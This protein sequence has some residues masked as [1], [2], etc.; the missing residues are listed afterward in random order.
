MEGVAAASD[1]AGTG[2]KR[3]AAVGRSRPCCEG[4]TTSKA[5]NAAASDE[6]GS[7]TTHQAAVGLSIFQQKSSTSAEVRDAEALYEAGTATKRKAD[8]SG[9]CHDDELQ[10]KKVKLEREAASD[11]AGGASTTDQDDDVRAL[12]AKQLEA[13][14]N[15]LANGHTAAQFEAAMKAVNEIGTIAAPLDVQLAHLQAV[16]IDH[17]TRAIL[18]ASK[19]HYVHKHLFNAAK[20]YRGALR[21]AAACDVALDSI[22]GQD[23]YVLSSTAV[24]STRAATPSLC[25]LCSTSLSKNWQA[26]PSSTGHAPQAG[27]ASSAQPADGEGDD[28][29]V[30]VGVTLAGERLKLKTAHNEADSAGKQSE[31][32][33]DDAGVRDAGEGA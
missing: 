16:T 31:D 2:T 29:V 4:G 32:K 28:E 30:V 27:A 23:E 14:E 26:C 7:G 20:K 15:A 1:E 12:A 22:N 8:S 10:G 25:K 13:A 6:A 33:V 18:M 17:R 19:L 24:A 21:W 9:L 3:Q 5:E 11:E